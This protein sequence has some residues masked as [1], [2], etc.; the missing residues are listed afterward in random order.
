MA[1]HSK[2]RRL[3][4]TVSLVIIVTLAAVVGWGWWRWQATREYGRVMDP[5][6][7]Q[8]EREAD[9]FEFWMVE[10]VQKI[11]PADKPWQVEVDQAHV[12]QWIA[13]RLPQ[14]AEN[15]QVDL[16]RW[17][18]NPM[19]AIREGEV[20]V[21]AQVTTEKLNKV[22]SFVYAP[23]VDEA[24]VVWL[25]VK[26]VYGGRL[27]VPYEMV[28]QRALSKIDPN[29]QQKRKNLE[30][31]QQRLQSVRLGFVLEDGRHVEVTDMVIEDG[32]MTLTCRTLSDV[33]R[34]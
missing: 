1:T 26:R 23:R 14:W 8:T 16:P 3:L 4:I 22:V 6:T 20:I 13:A 24:G 32:H 10:Q 33:P 7:E 21:A 2:L 29:D 17:L 9:Q 31:L 11:R 34:S 28:W 12:N 5:P 25:D 27:P 19:I 18:A 30:E 15:Q